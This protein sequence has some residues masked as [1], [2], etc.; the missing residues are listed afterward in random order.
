LSIN[1]DN[2]L[3]LPLDETDSAGFFLRLNSGGGPRID[4]YPGVTE[5]FGIFVSSG[6]NSNNWTATDFAGLTNSGVSAAATTIGAQFRFTLMS[7]NSYSM[8]VVRLSDGQT[9]LSRAG[10]LSGAI[11][12]SIDSLEIALFG[13]GSGNG[14]AGPDALPTGEREFFFNNLYVERTDNTGLLVGDYNNNGIVDAADY[15][16]WRNGLD[17]VYTLEHY[18]IWRTHF[19]QTVPAPSGGASATVRVPEPTAIAL[20]FLMTFYAMTLAHRRSQC[21]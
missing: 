21:R 16:V 9:L 10:F 18:D 20:F 15:V 7:T 17:T 12:A 1:F 6:F 3:P 4:S 2:P 19:G 8:S 11:G 14:L 5:R 13:N